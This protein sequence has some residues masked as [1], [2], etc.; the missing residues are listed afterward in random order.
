MFFLVE[1]SEETTFEFLQ[2][3][4]ILVWFWLCIKT[5]TGDTDYESLKFATRKW[6]VIND[7]NNKDYGEGN[8]NGATAKFNH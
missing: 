2:N 4:A 8:K 7:Q 5:K 3:A 6:Y 1:K